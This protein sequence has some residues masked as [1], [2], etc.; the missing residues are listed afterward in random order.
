[1]SQPLLSSMQYNLGEEC[2][3]SVFRRHRVLECF[4]RSSLLHNQRV[5]LNSSLQQ[6]SF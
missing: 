6:F 4:A 5:V 3:P 1:M 2:V